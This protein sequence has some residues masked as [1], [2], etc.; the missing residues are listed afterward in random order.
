MTFIARCGRSI[1]WPCAA[2]NSSKPATRCGSA[3]SPSTPGAR[4]RFSACPSA[5]PGPTRCSWTG[6]PGNIPSSNPT[7]TGLTQLGVA[8]AELGRGLAFLDEVSRLIWSGATD[9]WHEGDH[10]ARA[11]VR[12]GLDADQLWAMVDSQ[13][14]R[15]HAVVENNQ[16]AQRLAGHYGVPLMVFEGEPFYGQDRFDQF[17]WRLAQHGLQRRG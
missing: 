6:R 10:L 8:A 5:G 12:A 4:P 15:L 11:A 14:E 1:P 16:A 9:N 17:K 7:S 2:R 13:A 3:T